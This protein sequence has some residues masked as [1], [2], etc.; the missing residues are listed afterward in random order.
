MRVP[1]STSQG[2]VGMP[3]Y[4]SLT[5]IGMH[6]IFKGALMHDPPHLEHFVFNSARWTSIEEEITI[7]LFLFE[8]LIGPP[9]TS[10]ARSPIIDA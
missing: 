3:S 4:A 10:S 7:W 8:L 6:S 1:T 9:R 2:V 5:E